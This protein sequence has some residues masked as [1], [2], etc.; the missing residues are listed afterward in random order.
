[1]RPFDADP[2]EE[3]KHARHWPAGVRANADAT[4]GSRI[5]CVRGQSGPCVIVERKGNHRVAVADPAASRRVLSVVG[6]RRRRS[7]LRW[8]SIGK[9]S[10]GLDHA[11]GG[12]TLAR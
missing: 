10:A 9:A 6:F 7:A 8:R 12:S 2:A 1:M 11:V 4:R 5:T 3:R